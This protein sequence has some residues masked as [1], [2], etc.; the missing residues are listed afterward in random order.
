MSNI[1]KLTL[2]KVR[3]QSPSS[4]FCQKSSSAM[5]SSLSGSWCHEQQHRKLK[6][7]FFLQKKNSDQPQKKHALTHSSAYH[8]PS[9]IATDSQA[10]LDCTLRKFICEI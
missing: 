3:F 9:A 10:H 2:H 5:S 7:W 1:I 4:I 8:Q 6:S